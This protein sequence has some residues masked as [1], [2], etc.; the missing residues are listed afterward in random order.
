MGREIDVI[1]KQTSRYLQWFRPGLQAYYEDI[2]AAGRALA[3]A[4]LRHIDGEDPGKLQS[5]SLPI[6]PEEN[7]H[8]FGASFQPSS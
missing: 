3:D 1:T 8:E 7:I 2:P 6:D 4:L 5:L